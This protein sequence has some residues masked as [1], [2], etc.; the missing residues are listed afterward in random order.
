MGHSAHGP[1]GPADPFGDPPSCSIPALT[2]LGTRCRCHLRVSPPPA[3]PGVNPAG[4]SSPMSCRCRHRGSCVR[5]SPRLPAASAAV[6]QSGCLLTRHSCFTS[7]ACGS[8]S[9]GWADAAP[10][11]QADPQ[12]CF[13]SF[14]PSGVW[15]SPVGGEARPEPSGW[16]GPALASGEGRMGWERGTHSRP[17]LS[18]PPSPVGPSRAGLSAFFFSGH[19]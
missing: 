14:L 18:A 4:V 19:I 12:T 1:M 9:E 3:S 13:L 2:P 17:L 6:I 7:Q 8:G 11:S 5:S 15:E 10:T 16:A